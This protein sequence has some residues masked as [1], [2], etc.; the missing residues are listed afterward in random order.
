MKSFQQ[1]K[2][3]DLDQVRSSNNETMKGLDSLGLM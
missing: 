1:T 2:E 3:E